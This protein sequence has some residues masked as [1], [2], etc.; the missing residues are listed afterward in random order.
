MISKVQSLHEQPITSQVTNDN[1]FHAVCDL[2]LLNPRPSLL[3]H[4]VRVA[5]AM[6]VNQRVP[7]IIDK[8]GYR[9]VIWRDY[10]SSSNVLA[11]SEF[12]VSSMRLVA[13]QNK[14]Y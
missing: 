6:D 2:V 11:A 12:P 13:Y 5:R 8:R 7:S 1:A 9:Q 10:P 4:R 14:L 3:A